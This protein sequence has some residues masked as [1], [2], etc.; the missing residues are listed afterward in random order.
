MT[1]Q[2]GFLLQEE[3]FL[4]EE[5]STLLRY[6]HQKTGARVLYMKNEDPNKVFSIAFRTPPLGSTGNCHI[7]EHCVLNGSRKYRTKEP[8]MDFLKGSLQTFLNAMT[9][10]DKTMYP[11]ASR[12]DADFANLMDMYLDAV[13]FPNVLS[14]PLVF[15]QEGWRHEVFD[16]ES[17]LQYQGVVYNEM[18]GALSAA[19]DQIFEQISA[20]LY[21]G[22]IYAQN[23]GGDPYEIPTLDY[24]AFCAYHNTYYHPS[25]AWVFLYGDLDE[26]ST[27]ARMN[28]Y[29]SSFEPQNVNSLPTLVPDFSTPK[30]LDITYACGPSEPTEHKSYLAYTWLF[31]E[32]KNER[33]AMLAQLLPTLLVNSE[34]AVLKK[35]L[36][37]ALGCEDVFASYQ[38][39]RQPSLVIVAKHVDPHKRAQFSDIIEQTLRKL[40]AEG[41]DQNLLQATLNQAEFQLREKGNFPTK[42]VVLAI[43]ALT[44]WLYERS[45]IA[46]L[47][48]RD[49]LDA[50]Q[51]EQNQ[52]I[53]E[54]Y[55]RK[56]LLENPRHLCSVH[57]PEPGKNERR[58]AAQKEALKTYRASL[59]ET[60]LE[61]LIAENKA[62]RQRQD[63]P[64]TP[65]R[66]ATIPTLTRADL[67]TSLPRIPRALCEEADAT[68]LEHALPTAG[69]LYLDIVFDASHI[70]VEEAPYAALVCELIG[71]LDTYKR[72]YSDYA[73]EELLDTG[74]IQTNFS[75]F[76]NA[77]HMGE[78][79]RKIIV[80]TNFLGTR[81][82]DRGLSLLREQLFETDFSDRK[83]IIEVL[84]MLLSQYRMSLTDDA[85]RIAR[86]RALSSVTALSYY[87]Q[88]LN[89]LTYY[90][91]LKNLTQEYTAEAHEKL[92]AVYSKLFS[93]PHRIIN[94]TAEAASLP[95]LHN[96]VQKSLQTY[97]SQ[98]HA[99]VFVDFL[100]TPKKEAFIL[101]AD[102]Q[103]VAMGNLLREAH[104]LLPYCGPW[105]VLSGIL[106]TE[107]LY[108]EIRAKGGAYGTG[109]NLSWTGTVSAWSYRDP[110][111]RQTVET[112]CRLGDVVRN[113]DLS[114]QDLNRMIIG[115]VGAL[116]EPMTERQKG[117]FDLSN[118]L[119]G[120][121][122]ESYDRILQEILQTD[123]AA[124]HQTANAVE[125]AFSEP[126]LAVIGSEQAIL[127]EKSYFDC[128]HRL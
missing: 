59:S 68:W 103:Y 13:F 51:K 72:S 63:T 65:E 73:N 21:E 112:Y 42:G 124:L 18:K 75:L 116:D 12:N 23:S 120:R 50:L 58:D 9:F 31:D 1:E 34:A 84:R 44:P 7:L 15:R 71:L 47:A 25:N 22:S 82:L 11:V 95:A 33:E 29:F 27:F 111:L 101:S 106:S 52:G 32:P 105:A 77:N 26:E 8:F 10:P 128:I 30:A 98:R 118:Y 37:R 81:T 123:L 109:A 92:Q 53:F 93:A 86:D 60:Q 56:N 61:A 99:P 40:V 76:P 39:L 126:H 87:N 64:N 115:A 119:S 113:L 94:L 41:I 48:Y 28:E 16:K 3:R 97:P 100:A 114:A 108:N 35:A 57:R 70:S 78:F 6:V 46:T 54:T 79:Q 80:S 121:T 74:G 85:H 83:R 49:D 69:I 45:P 125:G 66:K 20:A 19:E 4:E 17:P 55:L 102:V 127:A 96:A 36:L 91:V 89:G 107:F 67:P 117:R 104:Q 38:T 14:D 90:Q 88:S 62:L 122:P 110:H 24:E 2:T 43:A 5:Q